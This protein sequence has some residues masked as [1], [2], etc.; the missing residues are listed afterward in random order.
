MSDGKPVPRVLIVDDTWFHR[1]NLRDFFSQRGFEIVGE[2]QD[3]R[4]G[5]QLYDKLKPD[6]VTMDVNM[7]YMDGIEAVRQIIQNHPDALIIMISGMG[8]PTTINQ[9]HDAGAFSFMT[10]PFTHDDLILRIA[11][12][13]KTKFPGFFS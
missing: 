9:A 6:L 2:A 1:E 5:V 12:V 7:P 4:T 8:N 3:G 10:K 13:L 11:G